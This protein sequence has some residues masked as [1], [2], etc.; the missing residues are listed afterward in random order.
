MSAG[1]QQLALL[2]SNTQQLDL[3]QQ[4]L[5]LSKQYCCQ[6]GIAHSICSTDSALP[7]QSGKASYQL[8]AAH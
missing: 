8:A 4:L 3:L 1:R 6:H 7:A 5:L 2:G